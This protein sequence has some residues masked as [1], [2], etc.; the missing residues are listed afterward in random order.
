[1]T[2]LPVFCIEKHL[3]EEGSGEGEE[4]LVYGITPSMMVPWYSD[5]G[6]TV[7]PL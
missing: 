5:I 3:E 4:M 2:F 7:D 1:M 6:A